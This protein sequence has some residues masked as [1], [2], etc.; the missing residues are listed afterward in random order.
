MKGKLKDPKFYF[1]VKT[2]WPNI[3]YGK[4]IKQKNKSRILPTN[5]KRENPTHGQ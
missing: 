4:P 3:L 5:R 2:A 1:K